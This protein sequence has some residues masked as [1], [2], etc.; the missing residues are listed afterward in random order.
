MLTQQLTGFKHILDLAPINLHLSQPLN[1]PLTQLMPNPPLQKVS[2]DLNPSTLIKTQI[3][4]TNMNARLESRIHILNT[5]SSKEENTFVV[6]ES[7]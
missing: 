1:L 3:F 2:P 5:V 6:F 4:H 7:T